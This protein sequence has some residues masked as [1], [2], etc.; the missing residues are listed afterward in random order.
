MKGI[1]DKIK[2]IYIYIYIYIYICLYGIYDS[3]ILY[4]YFLNKFCK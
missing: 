2:I 1:R 3:F 4:L